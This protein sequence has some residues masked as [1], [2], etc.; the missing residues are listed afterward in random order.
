MLQGRL[1]D[2][3]LTAMREASARPLRAVAASA[4]SSAALLAVMACGGP[5][6]ENVAAGTKPP[7]EAE[8]IDL[9]ALGAG[10]YYVAVQAWDTPTGSV[11]YW[12]AVR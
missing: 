9:P 2:F 8:A 1:P 6:D 7:G 12:F 5:A 10:T 3:D 4:L 11:E